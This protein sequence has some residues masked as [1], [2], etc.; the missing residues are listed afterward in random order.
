[1]HVECGTEA[2]PGDKT[3]HKNE[4]PAAGGW[5]KAGFSKVATRKASSSLAALYLTAY[6]IGSPVCQDPGVKLLG[7]FLYDSLGADVFRSAQ[8]RAPLKVAGPEPSRA[9]SSCSPD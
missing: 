7:S 2:G 3:G 9:L 4:K 5:T 8:H 1:M 6:E